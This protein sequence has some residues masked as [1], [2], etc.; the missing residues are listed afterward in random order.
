[1]TFPSFSQQPNSKTT[2]SSQPNNIITRKS[3]N[4]NTRITAKPD[5]TRPDR[6]F[7]L[8]ASNYFQYERGGERESERGG[9]EEEPDD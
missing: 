8:S 5:Q 4:H 6:S 7:G 1:L 3:R 2:I 9:N